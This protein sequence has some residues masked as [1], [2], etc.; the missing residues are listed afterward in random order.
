[1]SVRPSPESVAPATFLLVRGMLIVRGRRLIRIGALAG[2]Q[3]EIQ[4]IASL[5]DGLFGSSGAAAQMKAY[6]I[7]SGRA[8]PDLVHWEIVEVRRAG[9][10]SEV[11]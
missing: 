4:R 6:L 10:A 5:V 7:D 9:E 1:M 11:A 8:E 2:E 3:V